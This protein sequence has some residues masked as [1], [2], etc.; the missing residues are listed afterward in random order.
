MGWLP[1]DLLTMAHYRCTPL[2]FSLQHVGDY[3]DYDNNDCYHDFKAYTGSSTGRRIVE[4]KEPVVTADKHAV[5]RE[6]VC[7]DAH[8]AV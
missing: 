8:R 4:W 7:N 6:A 3:D 5:A 2:S 1:S